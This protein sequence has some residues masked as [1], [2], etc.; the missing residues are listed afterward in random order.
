M[1]AHPGA[2]LGAHTVVAAVLAVLLALQVGA[3][4]PAAAADDVTYPTAVEPY[5]GYQPQTRCIKKP[6]AGILLLADWL[7]ARGGGYGTISRACAGSSRSEHKESRAFDWMLDAAKK[8]DRRLARA[9]L[10]ELFATD[11]DGNPHALARRMG[12][13]YVIWNDRMWAAY[14]DFEPKDYLSSSCK[15]RRT[16]SK[17]LRHRDHVHVS[18]VRRAAR[19]ETSWYLA[20]QSD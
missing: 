7:T 5:A 17:T 16:C 19:G 13:M 1:L 3:T 15:S 9:M 20:Q 2:R 11:A 18:L 8:K 14:D 10:D 12:V 6:K 4:S